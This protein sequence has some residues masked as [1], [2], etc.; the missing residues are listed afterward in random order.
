MRL[1]RDNYNESLYR[2]RAAVDSNSVGG[3][4][5]KVAVFFDWAATVP[6]VYFHR[7]MVRGEF[8]SLDSAQRW[9][10]SREIGSMEKRGEVKRRYLSGKRGRQKSVYM[11]K[12]TKTGA[13]LLRE[14]TSKLR[15]YSHAKRKT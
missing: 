12:L 11:V 3:E 14:E 2:L 13:R 7:L 9:C 15:G 4:A 5:H 10:F 1:G 8:T 6:P